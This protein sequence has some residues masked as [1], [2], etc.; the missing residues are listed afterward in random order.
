[1]VRKYGPFHGGL[2]YIYRFLYQHF[3]LEGCYDRPPACTRARAALFAASLKTL[4]WLIGER[5]LYMYNW[6]FASCQ[7]RNLKWW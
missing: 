4:K 5:L 1:M 7:Q 2:A 3:D 6:H